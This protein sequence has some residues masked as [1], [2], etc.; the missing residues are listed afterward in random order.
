MKKHLLEKLYPNSTG[1]NLLNI[2]RILKN[3]TEKKLRP[4]E[5]L[6]GKK[7]EK[8]LNL[9]MAHLPK[10]R[11]YY[12]PAF[13]NQNMSKNK[14]KLSNGGPAQGAPLLCRIYWLAGLLSSLPL[15]FSPHLLHSISSSPPLHP[16]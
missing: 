3:L 7:M 13:K 12:L 4:F 6:E 8:N 16:L 15:H 10:V 2:F 11:H 14:K 5:D 9:L 1:C